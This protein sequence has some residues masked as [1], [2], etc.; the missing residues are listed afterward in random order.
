MNLSTHTNSDR[1]AL[2]SVIARACRRLGGSTSQA[3]DRVVEL[4]RA[5]V[6]APGT[7]IHRAGDQFR[8]VFYVRSGAMKRTLIQEDGR[9]QVLGFPFP[10]DF[11]GL[12]AIDAQSHSTTVM[13][14]DM[15]SIVEIAYDAIEALAFE[16][17]EVA[18]L[19]YQKMSAALRDEHGWLAA[20]GRVF[21]CE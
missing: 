19:L 15:C 10:G 13:A 4:G 11:L 17:P 14:L 3:I 21:C 8:S 2:P 1:L 18:R 9:E 20:L 5:R 12:E 6:I 7:A 16:D